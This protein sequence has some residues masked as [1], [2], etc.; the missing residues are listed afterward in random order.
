M[1]RWKRPIAELPLHKGRMLNLAFAYYS[2]YLIEDILPLGPLAY[3]L[4]IV[5]I[6]RA[7]RT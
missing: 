6:H 1:A 5:A 2:V 4:Q 7:S 3:H